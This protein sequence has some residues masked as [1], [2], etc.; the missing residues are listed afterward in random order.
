MTFLLDDAATVF[1]TMR[2]WIGLNGGIE[3]SAISAPDAIRPAAVL[4]ERSDICGAERTLP[5]SA[6]L[7][8]AALHRGGNPHGFAV[9][10]D[11]AAG[12]INARGAQAFHDG[13]VGQD[14]RRRFAES[15]SCL[16]WWRTAS[17]ECASPPSAEAIEAVK[18][19]FNSKRAAIGRHV[20]VGGDARHRGFMHLDGVGDR[21]QIER[22]QMRDAMGEEAVLLAH[23]LGRNLQ[24]GAGALIERAHQPG[25]VLQRSR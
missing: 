22:P 20:F 15:I 6:L 10:R 8:T 23:D 4:R 9:L 13:V 25:R 11:R 3:S 19:Y 7:V 1:R 17:A 21:L 5:S 16:M 14:R 24:D 2:A 12:N 18:K